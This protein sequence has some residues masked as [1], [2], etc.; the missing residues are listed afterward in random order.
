MRPR[1]KAHLTPMQT[2][3]GSDGSFS[4]RILRHRTVFMHQNEYQCY[5]NTIAS[6]SSLVEYCR[7]LAHYYLTTIQ[8][9]SKSRKENEPC[10]YFAPTVLGAADTLWVYGL[11]GRARPRTRY[12]KGGALDC[13][14]L[15][16]L[17]RNPCPSL[18]LCGTC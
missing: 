7:L 11:Y 18:A 2:T 6:S 14:R 4:T 5:C 9:A 17:L 1:K 8:H 13:D 16:S 15:H 12:S 3:N 10:I